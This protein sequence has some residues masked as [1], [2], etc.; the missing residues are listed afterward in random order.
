MPTAPAETRPAPGSI[1]FDRHELAGAF[2]DIGTDL[3]LL[4][5][6]ILAGGLDSASALIMFGL[7]QLLTALRYRMPMPVQ[8]LKAMAAIVIAQKVSGEVL[9]GAGLAIGVVM[10]L[11]T[12]TGLIDLL[13][14][15]VPK[16]VVRGIQ[17]GLGLQLASIALTN[18]VRTEGA[19]GYVLAG[20][21]FCLILAFMGNRR[22]PAALLV[23]GLGVVYAC[24]F[25]VRVSTFAE[26]VGLR[27]PELHK[28][29]W[30]DV[31]KGFWLLALPQIPLSLGNSVLA[32]RQVAE[33]L[34]PQRRLTVR[35][36]AFTYSLMNI[37]NPFFGGVPTCH[38]SGGMA[39]HY[40][41]GAR[42][43]GSVILYGCL[44]LTLGLFFSGVFGDVVKIF[45][46]P[47]LG[48]LL[49]FEGLAMMLLVRDQTG[50][51]V[52]L[53]LALLVGLMAFGLPNG[54]VVGLVVGTILAYLTRFRPE[55]LDLFAH[56]K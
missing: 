55:S 28:P 23:I 51:K 25:K 50:S 47:I 16:V 2:G 14:R 36:I 27:V 43:G 49:L 12:S 32:T 10:L 19:Q 46:L 17:F 37:I 18:Y 13:A 40:A 5:G 9:L 6:V 29:A 7:M 48:V 38:G 26:G 21:G 24:V 52:D 56:R 1:R 8:P 54:Y 11:L 15:V 20:A 35:S 33:D 41:F 3:P 44:Y 30:A 31:T 39:G 42:T 53:P 22:V 34:F 4:V 45:P